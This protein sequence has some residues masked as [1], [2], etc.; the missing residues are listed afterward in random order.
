MAL[1]LK[2]H[3]EPKAACQPQDKRNRQVQDMDCT[4]LTV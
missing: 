3:F 4:L 2:I 1:N